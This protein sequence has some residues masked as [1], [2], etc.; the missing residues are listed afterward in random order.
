M[1]GYY[2]SL[3]NK[4]RFMDLEKVG[5]SLNVSIYYCWEF[6]N[7]LFKISQF[8]E[9]RDLTFTEITTYICLFYLTL[10]SLGSIKLLHIKE[11]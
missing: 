5:H 9:I 7:H 1:N 6:V 4:F 2:V 10:H 8:N 11:L 3:Q